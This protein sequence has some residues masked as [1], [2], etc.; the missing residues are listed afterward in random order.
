MTAGKQQNSAEQ[1]TE[2]QQKEIKKLTALLK[3]LIRLSGI[4]TFTG[5]NKLK[6]WRSINEK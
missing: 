4:K 3:K 5:Y 6:Q 1:L 2:Y